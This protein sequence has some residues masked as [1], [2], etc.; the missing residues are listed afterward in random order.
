MEYDR[1]RTRIRGW[2]GNSNCLYAGY[3]PISIKT[4]NKSEATQE[5]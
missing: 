5:K 1:A 4:D 2:P 3:N